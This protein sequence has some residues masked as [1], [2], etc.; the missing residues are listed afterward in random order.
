M[1]YIHPDHRSH[2]MNWILAGLILTSLVGVF[3]LVALYNNIV[4]LNHNIAAA[5]T[6]LD[7]VGAQATALNN[8]VV[9][10]MGDVAS[11]D[12]AAQDG[13]VQDNHPQYFNQSWPIASQQ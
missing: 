4:D 13:L 9:A 8:Q 6:E 7:S 5:K 10:A 12:L 2:L 11:G 3:W 1:T